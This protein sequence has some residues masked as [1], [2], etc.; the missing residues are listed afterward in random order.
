[1]RT[2]LL[3]II[4][5]FS[6]GFCIY[7]MLPFILYNLAAH[8]SCYEDK[9]EY[10]KNMET[11]I[12]HPVL[13]TAYSAKEEQTDSTPF[14]AAWGDPVEE[15]TVGVSRDLL[16]KGLGRNAIIYLL[17]YGIY[18]VND[19]MHP[20]KKNQLDLF[21]FDNLRARELSPRIGYYIIL[22]RG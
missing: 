12:I 14:I 3:R 7:H 20:R 4:V 22:K 13:L 9:K 18:R 15:C 2:F 11:P 17:G 10:L 1:M 6:I 5:G 16:K 19:K 21:F 8:T